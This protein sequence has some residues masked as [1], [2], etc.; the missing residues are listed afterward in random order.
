MACQRL[1]ESFFLQMLGSEDE[2]A[3]VAT[4]TFLHSRIPRPPPKA[5]FSQDR[6]EKF[7]SFTK[8]SLSFVPLAFPEDC[9]SEEIKFPKFPYIGWPLDYR[10][11]CVHMCARENA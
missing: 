5:N 2:I 11:L 3:Q 4:A 10:L 9:R 6:P 7:Q 1:R 8:K